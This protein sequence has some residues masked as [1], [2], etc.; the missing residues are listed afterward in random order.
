VSGKAVSEELELF[1]AEH[2]HSLHQ[3]E[4]LLL[5]QR[6]APRAWT[7]AQTAAELRTNP[8][9]A[10]A[11]LAKL[12]ERGL[13]ATS[14]GAD[15]TYTYAPAAPELDEAVIALAEMYEERRLTVIDLIFSSP[16]KPEAIRAFADAFRLRGRDRS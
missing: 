16:E 1:V 10:A 6:T 2:I 14:T 3:L 8:A 13:L 9:A 7:A 11:T 15:P 12:A 4:V 5:L